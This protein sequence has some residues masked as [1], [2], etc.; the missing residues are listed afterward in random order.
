MT[1]INDIPGDTSAEQRDWL[2]RRWCGVSD[3]LRRVEKQ[4]D[5]LRKAATVL[6][7]HIPEVDENRGVVELR[8]N[9]VVRDWT[10]D[11]YAALVTLY[12]AAAVKAG[13]GE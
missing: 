8:V 1:T 12:R 7:E 13:R 10:P 2:F 11:L 9:G 6:A 4:R 3:M 5:E